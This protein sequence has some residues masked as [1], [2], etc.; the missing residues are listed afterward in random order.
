MKSHL[1]DA[2][3]M[4][5]TV[6]LLML[7]LFA[8][9]G[10][11]DAADAVAAKRPNILF[12]FAD[13]WAWPHASCLG[14]P[15]V[16]TPAFDRIAKEGVLFRNAHAAAPS[17]SPSRAAILTGQWHWRLEQGANLHGFIPAK[18]AV[19]PDLLETAGYFV[20]MAGKGYG[21][22]SN[23][24]RSRNAAG[25]GFKNFDAFLA[26]RPEGKPFCFW[27]GSHDPHRPYQSGIGIRSGMDPAKVFVPPYL[28]DNA[29]T[30]SDICD[31]LYQAEQFDQQCA[32]I[33][34]ALEKTGEL[35]ETLIV[36][37]GDNG[38]P[39]PRSKVSCYDSGTH[40]ALAIRWG[41]RVKGGRSVEDFVSLSDLAPTFLEA[42]GQPAPA[43]MTA[44]SLMPLLL[45]DKSGQV[46]PAR[47][48]TLTGMERHA[49]TGRTD[50]PQ[51]NVG[52]PMRTLLTK[53]FHYIRNFKPDRWPAGDPP[54][55]PLPPSEKIAADTYAAFSD[56]DCGPTK[57]FLVTRRD[58]PG[59]K[60]FAERAFAKRPARELYDLR[61][62]PYELNNVAE[63]PTYA[64]TVKNLD[65]RLM[66]ELKATGDPRASGLGDT[67]ATTEPEVLAKPQPDDEAL[68]TLPIRFHVT[69]GATM[70]VKGQQMEGWVHPADLVG[71]VLQEINRIWKPAN[72]QFIVER[73][74]VEP[75]LQPANFAE[76]LKSI[77]NSKR[78]E[79]EKPGSKRTANIAKL[80]DPAQRHQTV[81]NVYLLPYIGG[82][83]QGYANLGGNQ[84]VIGVWTD[85]PSRGEKPPVKTLL[86]EPEPMKFGSL[87]RTI[88][89]ELGHNLTLVHPDKS[90]K[91]GIGRLMGGSKQGYGLTLEEIGKARLSARKH[92]ATQQ[93]P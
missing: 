29:I 1:P 10:T 17:C 57:A 15:G 59:V 77:E 43:A 46:E 72:I 14:C 83:Y 50:G 93:P 58:D 9:V 62:D 39:F 82:T 60:P 24:G 19:Y 91:S 79:E 47:D 45:S 3:P 37:S 35:D 20:G 21:P 12:L 38:W 7:G 40:Q 61:R 22:G 27:F 92:L 76:L 66:A 16:K 80:L 85:K 90:V 42:A 70:T 87:A 53:D 26:A 18:F 49:R 64:D 86:V 32:T 78:G 41:A 11:L 65:A 33:L 71:P 28:P 30:R 36:V 6:I 56:C 67:V 5:H 8:S 54:K 34:A 48:H 23:Q 75:L 84:A 88:A 81:L 44:R 2:T 51:Q 89:H 31:Y 73:A 55:E 52:Y 4:K 13:D 74:Q 69:Q 68:L 63:D 25:P